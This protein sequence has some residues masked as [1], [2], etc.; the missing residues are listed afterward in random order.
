ML[1]SQQGSLRLGGGS[2]GGSRGSAVGQMYQRLFCLTR[3]KKYAFFFLSVRLISDYFARQVVKKYR[4]VLIFCVC[5]C[6]CERVCMCVC[7]YVSV[8]ESVYV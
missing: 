6:V 1:V 4:Y 2:W 3:S 8:C 7:G 5:V